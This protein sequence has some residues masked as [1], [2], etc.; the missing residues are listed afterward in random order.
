[1]DASQNTP[2]RKYR[3]IRLSAGDYLLPGNDGETIFRIAKYVEDGTLETGDGET[4]TGEFWA[5]WRW[6]RPRTALARED[7]GYGHGYDPL[8]DWDAW[9]MIEDQFRTRQEAIDAALEWEWRRDNP[10]HTVARKPVDIA[11]MFARQQ[12]SS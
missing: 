10:I 8:E 1:M 2:Q 11:A 6:P 5:A 7:Y 3:M 12:E 4:I 9:H